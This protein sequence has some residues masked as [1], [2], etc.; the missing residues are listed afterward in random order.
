MAY[1]FEKGISVLEEILKEDKYE[2][3]TKKILDKD[4]YEAI[5]DEIHK[6]KEEKQSDKTTTNAII[7][8][9]DNFVGNED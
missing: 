7:A 1:K 3:L 9:L 8:I 5:F 2:P 4:L 6:Y